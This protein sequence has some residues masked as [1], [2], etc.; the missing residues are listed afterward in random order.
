MAASAE[1]LEVTLNLPLL[2]ED[3]NVPYAFVCYKRALRQ[4]H[5]VSRPMADAAFD[6]PPKGLLV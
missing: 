6:S 2:Y 3:K 5:G 1:P 4:A